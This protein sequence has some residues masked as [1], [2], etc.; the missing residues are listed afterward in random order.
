[1]PLPADRPL[2]LCPQSLWKI[3]PENDALF[4]EVLVANPR[5]LLVLFAGRH[6][7][8]TAA[9][10]RRLVTELERHGL[11]IDECVRVLPQ[12][13]PTT[14]GFAPKRRTTSRTNA[15]N[16]GTSPSRPGAGW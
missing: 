3:H 6:P 5:M 15:T 14:R 1:M 12:E 13:A 7:A 2:L 10:T 9:F 16:P 11:A 4:A 8:I